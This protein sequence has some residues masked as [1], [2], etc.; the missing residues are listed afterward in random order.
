MAIAIVLNIERRTR[1]SSFSRPYYGTVGRFIYEV[2]AGD[3]IEST[4]LPQK[5]AAGRVEGFAL[6]D[7]PFLFRFGSTLGARIE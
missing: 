1:G 6:Y 3:A 4:E 2:A 5:M 7:S